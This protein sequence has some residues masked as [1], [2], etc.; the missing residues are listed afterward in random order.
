MLLVILGII[1]LMGEWF[2]VSVIFRPIEIIRNGLL[3]SPELLS[4][5]FDSYLETSMSA[6]YFQRKERVLMHIKFA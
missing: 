4:V 1:L 5:L 6:S 2:T 3:D